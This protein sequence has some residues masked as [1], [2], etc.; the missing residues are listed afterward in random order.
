MSRDSS[1]NQSTISNLSD[2]DHHVFP[3]GSQTSTHHEHHT[4]HPLFPL[5]GLAD[6]AAGEPMD[7]LSIVAY[8]VVG[9]LIILVGLFGNAM[10]LRT[11][12]GRTP[13]WSNGMTYTY[14]KWLA[15]TDTGEQQCLRLFWT[16]DLKM[17]K[18]LSFNKWRFF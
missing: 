4:S 17:V 11:F 5:D 6:A 1:S 15:I 3:G 7:V 2:D 9:P 14:L 12:L 16:I 13:V 18:R 8:G 10:T